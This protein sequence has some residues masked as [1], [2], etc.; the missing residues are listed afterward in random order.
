MEN[1]DMFKARMKIYCDCLNKDMKKNGVRIIGEPLIE[2][3][4]DVS[5]LGM[6]IRVNN[7][8][9]DKYF[10]IVVTD[11]KYVGLID[12]AA[13]VPQ[14]F[15][16]NMVDRDDADH[17]LVLLGIK[18]LNS[19]RL[20]IHLK[21]SNGHTTKKEYVL[22]NGYLLP[23]LDGY[24]YTNEHPKE[25]DGIVIEGKFDMSTPSLDAYQVWYDEYIK[26][27]KKTLLDSNEYKGKRT[28]EQ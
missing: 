18:M 4:F 5:V 13:K 19:Y 15:I 10:R 16:T 11:N 14:S 9:D 2:A 28:L 8:P 3:N 21:K 27:H 20:Q 24:V 22:K 12:K 25:D 7:V 26:K 6:N 17:R 1:I 23:D